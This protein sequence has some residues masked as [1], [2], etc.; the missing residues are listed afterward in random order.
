VQQTSIC[1]Q[2]KIHEKTLLN[3][4]KR[5]SWDKVRVLNNKEEIKLFFAILLVLFVN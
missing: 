3:E 1:T 2:Q 4:I 5:R